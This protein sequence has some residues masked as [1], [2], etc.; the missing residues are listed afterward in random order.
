MWAQSGISCQTTPV[1]PILRSE[2]V[3]ERLGDIVLTCTGAPN[4]TVRG[5]L[6]VFLNT[7]VTNR[8]LGSGN[9]DAIL[10]IDEVPAGVPAR[11][12]G[13][14]RVTWS[15]LTITIPA[16]R[17]TSLRISNLRGDASIGGAPA[18]P[19]QFGSGASLPQQLTAQLAFNPG[20]LLNFTTTNFPVGVTER[21][22]YATTLTRIVPSQ[23]GSPL[24]SEPASFTAFIARGTAFASTR[25]TEGHATAFEPRQPQTSQGTRIM[26][27][28]SGYPADA[29]LF[30]PAAVAGLNATVPTR[31]GDF[32]GPVSGGQY[33]AGS[34]TL[35]LARVLFTDPQGSGGSPYSPQSGTL[36]AMTEVP[37]QDG[38]GIAVYEVLDGN[39][40][41]RESAQIPV[42]I[43]L[44]RS[45]SARS[46]TVQV[47]TTF[48]PISTTPTVSTFAPIPR[49]LNVAAPTDCGYLR[50]CESYVPKLEV[51]PVL[52]RFRL[53]RGAGTELR[54]IYMR[55]EGGGL[56]PFSVTVEYNR[57]RGWIFLTPTEGNEPVMIRMV[58][59]ALPEMEPGMYTATV[60]IDAGAAGVRRVPIELEVVN[61]N[62]SPPPPVG[63]T[64][65][66]TITSVVHGATF[67]T[68]AVARGSLVTLRGTN[69][70]GANLAVTFD[71]KPARVVFSSASQINLQVPSDLAGNTSQVRVTT[72]GVASE[73][74]TVQVAAASPGIFNPGI[75]NQDG[76]VNS[77]TNPADV[78]TV[79]Q[80]FA[81][82][83]LAPDASGVV[84]ARLHDITYTRL[85]Y[86]GAAPGLS[87]VQQ[88]NVP[89]EQ[90]WPTMMTEVLLCTTSGGSRQCSPPARIWLRGNQ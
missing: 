12:D 22:L 3:A 30:V 52:P 34:N 19:P 55:N 32:G 6:T 48:G 75:L 89:V 28:F 51:D 88:V 58:V 15:G 65:K 56:M 68:G 8:D 73:A 31:A 16:S 85:P 2:G 23:A 14:N 50:D 20:G 42:F 41:A 43:G 21:G 76:T 10:A 74:F 90:S 35:L 9:L 67:Q 72:G 62:T 63:T 29:R 81:T 25:V 71:G 70:A 40:Q 53:T 57:G 64:P 86:A 26:L 84:E 54:N 7:T 87:G 11:L 39:P 33:T 69:L 47:Q 5:N 4:T 78:G 79:V 24:P 18:I 82:G 49:F 77:S 17:Q 46:V 36:D 37:L 61:S 60:I 66:P 27:R 83:L 44:A 80:I 1:T 13:T 45:E 59:S 38:A